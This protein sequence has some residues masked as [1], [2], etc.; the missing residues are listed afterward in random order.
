[1]L[2]KNTY[3]NATEHIEPWHL[4]DK[5]APKAQ[6]RENNF[7]GIDWLR[8]PSLLETERLEMSLHPRE[9]WQLTRFDRTSPK[10]MIST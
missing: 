10:T 4:L 6:G 7:N 8:M 5:R 9:P 3:I 2:Q 1:M